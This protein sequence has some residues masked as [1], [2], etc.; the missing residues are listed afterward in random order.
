MRDYG[1]EICT[2]QAFTSEAVSENAYDLG[3]TGK[4]LG[5]SG[6]PLYVHFVVKTAFETLSSG[7]HIN[8]ITSDN[9]N[10]SSD[11]GVGQF[12]SVAASDDCVI[13]VTD[14]D[15]AGDHLT[16]A[17]PPGFPFKRYIGI[18]WVPVSEAASAGAA[19]CR[20]SDK[21]EMYT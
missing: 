5:H 1:K 19:D 14:I 11:V 20:V 4:Q 2:D 8:V 16:F 18:N 6:R 3:A 12:G 15:A 9:A 7:V 17:L 13:P 21:P 10:L